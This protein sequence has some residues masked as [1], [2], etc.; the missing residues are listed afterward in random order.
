MRTSRGKDRSLDLLH[1]HPLT[2]IVSGSLA[3]LLQPGQGKSFLSRVASIR[4]HIAEELGFLAPEIRFSLSPKLPP[5]EYDIRVHSVRAA[6]GRVYPDRYLVIGPEALLSR[7]PGERTTDPT[8]GIPAVW[9]D[10][11]RLGE[12]HDIG[13]IAFD[14]GSVIATHI[15]EVIRRHADEFLGR[16]AVSSLLENLKGSHP[17]LVKDLTATMTLRNLQKIL[18]NLL[19]ERVSI[20]NLPLILETL[21]DHVKSGQS[22]T[23]LTEYVRRALAPAICAGLQNNQKVIKGIS[24]DATVERLVLSNI[25]KVQGGH[26]LSLEQPLREQMLHATEK[27]LRKLQGLPQVLLCS[28][29][30]RLYLRHLLERDYPDLFVLSYLEVAPG[31]KFE[32][33]GAIRVR[34]PLD[35]RSP[36]KKGW[37]VVKQGAWHILR[38]VAHRLEPLAPS[39][40]G[41]GRSEKTQKN[42]KKAAILLRTLPLRVSSRVFSDLGPEEVRALTREMSMMPEKLG[43]HQKDEVIKEFLKLWIGPNSIRSLPL[44]TPDQAEVLQEIASEDPGKVAALLQDNWLAGVSEFGAR[45]QVSS[46][47]PQGPHGEPSGTRPAAEPRELVSPPSFPPGGAVGKSP[48][49]EERAA[50]FLSNLSSWTLERLLQGLSKKENEAIALGTL[51]LERIPE[52]ARKEVWDQILRSAHI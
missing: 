37:T 30:V 5:N 12:A 52:R 27:E 46:G 29:K 18:Q 32:I 22:P 10:R 6:V 50:I 43:Q 13:C 21:T 49:P 3:D 24:I 7:V 38:L 9:V 41:G 16:E 1:I 4:D 20:R 17:A 33:L 28:P 35:L 8:Y 19:K 15:T 47:R 39:H 25:R 44:S 14:A 51:R 42:M 23:V 34:I 36:L 11:S 48:G 31:A 40:Q 26:A 2:V 45:H